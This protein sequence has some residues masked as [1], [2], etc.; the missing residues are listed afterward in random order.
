MSQASPARQPGLSLAR[1]VE[2]TGM[3]DALHAA[4]AVAAMLVGGLVLRLRDA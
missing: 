2:V 4:W 3:R 1:R